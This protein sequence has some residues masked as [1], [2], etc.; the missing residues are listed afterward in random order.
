[1]CRKAF[2]VFLYRLSNPE[3]PHINLGK[4][5]EFPEQSAFH[6]EQRS[7]NNALWKI[8]FLE[9]PNIAT[10][11]Y[12]SRIVIC[13]PKVIKARYKYVILFIFIGIAAG[14]L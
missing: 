7:A 6:P 11:L 9:F 8:I 14:I 12:W 2:P 13:A 10:Y 5:K 3:I 1:M 4:L